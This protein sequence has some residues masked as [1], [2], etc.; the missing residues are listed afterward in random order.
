MLYVTYLLNGL[1]MIALP[2]GLGFFLSKKFRTSWRLFGLGAVSFF[3]S[4]VVH[5]P[6]L[7][8]LTVLFSNKILPAPPAAWKLIFNAVLLGL[9]AGLC[10]GLARYLFLRFAAKSARTWREA[11]MFGA[12]HGGIEAIL[13]GALVLVGYVNMV[14]MRNV[15]LATLGLSPDQQAAL[16]K[17]LAAYWSLPWYIS[18]LGAVERLFTLCLHLSATVMVMRSITQRNLLWL[19][20]AILWHSLMDACVVFGSG[21]GLGALQLEG[22]VGT[23][24]VVSLVIIWVL[25]PRQP[26]TVVEAPPSVIVAGAPASPRAVEKVQADAQ[27]Q[28]DQSKYTD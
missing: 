5:I 9:L 22:V 21:A 16:A 4:Q 7:Q 13:L 25:R 12:G 1:L 14:A 26:E 8:G 11:L 19:G 15:D 28:V 27:A 2:L 23:F 24:A 17:E 6:L 20:A 18:L 10:E 3:V